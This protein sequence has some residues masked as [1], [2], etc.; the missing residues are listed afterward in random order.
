MRVD[1]TRP[2]RIADHKADHMPIALGYFAMSEIA[3]CRIPTQDISGPK[4]LKKHV[5][6]VTLGSKQVRRYSH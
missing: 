3:P 5:G 1:K 4:W 2:G 6:R